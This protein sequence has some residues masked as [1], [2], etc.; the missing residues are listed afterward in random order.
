MRSISGRRLVILTVVALLVLGIMLYAY[1]KRKAAENAAM[2]ESPQPVSVEIAS[3]RY[4]RIDTTATAHG[5]LS[6]VQGGSARIASPIAGH[7]LQVYVREGDPVTAGQLLAVVDNRALSAQAAGA[8]NAVR[9]AGSQARSAE[10]D[11][12]A[13]AVDQQA[14]L[15]GAELAL[16]A[17]RADREYTLNQAR[18][19]LETAQTT[20]TRV[21][22]GA[23]PQ[24]IAQAEQAAAQ[25]RATRDR[26]A[27]EARRQRFLY[28]HGVAARRQVED[29]NTALAVANAA[30]A[31]AEEQVSL[32]RAGSR[33]ED[34]RAAQ[35]AVDNAR[36]ALSQVRASADARVAQAARA[37][38]QAR[39]T[40]PLRVAAKQQDA[41][42]SLATRQQRQNE[43]TAAQVTATSTILRA[44]LSGVITRRSANP[45]DMADPATPIIEITNTQRLN[46]QANIAPEDGVRVRP[47]MIVTVYPEAGRR[48]SLPGVV[49][50]I[51]GVD[52]QTNFMTAR[53]SIANPTGELRVGTFATAI[54]VLAT[55]PKAVVVPKSAVITRDGKQVVFTVGSNRVAHQRTVVVGG[56]EKGLVSIV[57]GVSPGDEVITLGQYAL[58][59]GASV[60]IMSR[61]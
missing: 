56:Q 23:R 12:R 11:A 54:I 39:R 45:G 26:A 52:P 53:V 57:S 3:A 8:K 17:A 43:Y 46:L 14:T 18:I 51:G 10:L 4:G 61:K 58:S 6:P 38:Q 30:Y 19:A 20:L 29:A 22:A 25:A 5:V 42:A 35:L 9:A 15:A 1:L 2:T 24:E 48:R 41:I 33:P 21:R 36:Q 34:I 28:E 13:T 16:S 37:L 7:V 31:S 49:T 47:G 40:T 27:T 50:S 60:R 44:P 32:L 55:N 59:D